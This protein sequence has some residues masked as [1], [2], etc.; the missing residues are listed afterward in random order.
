LPTELEAFLYEGAPW[1]LSCAD[2]VPVASAFDENGSEECFARLWALALTNESDTAEFDQAEAESCAQHATLAFQKLR[3]CLDNPAHDSREGVQAVLQEI[4]KHQ[5]RATLKSAYRRLLLAAVASVRERTVRRRSKPAAADS[6]L[7]SAN[8][9]R[10]QKV[11]HLVVEC[12]KVFDQ[13]ESKQSH[14]AWWEC[15]R[16]FLAEVFTRI[17]ERGLARELAPHP[18]V[19]IRIFGAA[20]ASIWMA[21]HGASDELLRAVR[22]SSAVEDWLRILKQRID[23]PAL[24]FDDRLRYQIARLKL[25][26]VRARAAVP[27]SGTDPAHTLAPARTREL[28]KAFEEMRAFLSHGVPPASRALPGALEPALIDFYVDAVSDVRGEGPAFPMSQKLLER[29]PQDFRLACLYATGALVC[30]QRERLSALGNRTFPA[31]IDP[32]LFARSARIWSGLADGVK[33]ATAVRPLLFDRLDRE[34]RKQC[35]MQLAQLALRRAGTRVD[36]EAELQRVQPFFERD[37]FVYREIREHT[38]LESALVFLASMMAS[39]QGVTL[40]LTESQSQQWVSYAHEIARQFT[41]GAELAR[42]HLNNVSRGFVLAPS[43]RDAA[44]A[45]LQDFQSAQSPTGAGGMAARTQR[46]GRRAREHDSSKQ[47]SSH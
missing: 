40:A 3:E 35:L 34:H 21:Q 46:R 7:Q 12:Q 23:P 41:V 18:G 8:T 26:R 42:H 36:Y 47:P 29:H 31:H 16:L 4:E 13:Y 43:V 10:A 38:A 2:L 44:R 20:S 37:N 28:L 30:G 19:L 6:A 15:G 39:L 14:T 33:A 25:L 5:G 32:E 45:R 27:L 22:V 9:A 11:L 17:T 1:S 24:L